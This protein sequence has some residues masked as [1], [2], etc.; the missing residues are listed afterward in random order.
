MGSVLWANTLHEG[1]CTCDQNDLPSLL[2]N[3]KKID[4]IMM[5]VGAMSVSDMCDMTDLQVNADVIE[6]PDHMDST[7]EL[8]IEQGV[9]VDLKIARDSLVKLRD[10]LE[11]QKPRIGLIRDAREDILEELELTLRFIA[12]QDAVGTRFNFAYVT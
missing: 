9:W 7:D 2:A 5:A 12:K 1:V 11:E 4:K 3:Q 8:M 6:M 10:H